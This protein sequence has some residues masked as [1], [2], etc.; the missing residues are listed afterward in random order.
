MQQLQLQKL[1][2]VLGVIVLKQRQHFVQRGLAQA[3]VVI[4]CGK[5][6]GKGGAQ[7]EAFHFFGMVR[8]NPLRHHAA[9][10]P[11]E[12]MGVRPQLP[13]NIARQRGNIER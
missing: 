6:F 12:Q 3:D 5:E 13:G 10:R 9:Q 4:R 1:A 8:G 2:H 7:C 11:A